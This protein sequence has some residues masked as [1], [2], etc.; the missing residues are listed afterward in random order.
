M[1]IYKQPRLEQYQLSTITTF[2]SDTS[3]KQTEDIPYPDVMAS[4]NGKVLKL[5]NYAAPRALQVPNGPAINGFLSTHG[6][7]NYLNI[8]Y[9]HIPARFRTARLLNLEDLTS[10]AELDATKYGPRCPQPADDIHILMSHMFEQL[11]MAQYTEEFSC[12]DV[13]IYT[14]KDI[15]EGTKLPV[16]AWIHGGAFR[17]GDNTTEFDGNHLVARSVS[18][19]QPIVVV[20]I[21]YRLGIFGFTTSK[22]IDAEAKAAGETSAVRGQGINDQKLALQ[23]IQKHISLFGGDPT[24]V[25]VGG[26]S[27]GAMSVHYLLRCRTDTPLFSRALICSAPSVAAS[28]RDVSSGQ[29]QF[30]ALV[31][32]AGISQKA[33]YQV[34][35]AA[36]RSYSADQ[37]VAMLPPEMSNGLPTPFIDPVWFADEEEGK[38]L[39]NGVLPPAD[40]WSRLPAW[41]PEI[42][43]GNT[44]DELALFIGRPEAV[45]WK[46]EEAQALLGAVVSEDPTQPNQPLVETIWDAPSIKVGPTPFGRVVA[47]GTHL[48]IGGPSHAFAAAVS[49]QCPNHKVYTYSIDIVDPFPGTA[50]DGTPLTKDDP[51]GP[52]SGFAWHSFGNAIMFYQPACQKDAELGQTADKITAAH[53]GLM[54]GNTLPDWEPFGVAGKRMSWNGSKS[55]LVEL[56]LKSSDPV[57]EHLKTAGNEAVLKD[58]EEFI[59][60]PRRVVKLLG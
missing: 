23:W 9:A 32:A 55:A 25:T 58:Y 35:L 20:T 4:R 59:Q 7:N 39:A 45:A 34:K 36:L 15:P 24:K 49:R 41:C 57:H 17:A 30:D 22:E 3:H 11:P 18:L 27:A 44:K 51:A 31:A 5:D 16:F 33:P 12:L 21:N 47:F 14:P 54:N 26:E 19:G 2:V 48:F 38:P 42:I 28:L 13:N 6:V 29:A 46:T 43:L 52:L 40:Y 37:L 10:D 60:D 50:N 53:I 1:T 8:P 56:G